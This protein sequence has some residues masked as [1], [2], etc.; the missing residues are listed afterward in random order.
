MPYEA[1]KAIAATFC[2]KIR[3]ILTPLFGTDFPS[4]CISPSDRARFGRMIIDPAI[5]QRA[6]GIANKYQ[7]L[8]LQTRTLTLA[9]SENESATSSTSERRAMEDAALD[10]CPPRQLFPK[11][12]RH[13][14]TDSVGSAR[15]SSSEPYCVSPH[16]PTGS[17]W[18]PVNRPPPRSSEIVSMSRVPSPAHYLS[19]VAELQKKH[20][21]A[22]ESEWDTDLSSE[23][24]SDAIRTPELSPSNEDSEMPDLDAASADV[25]T[26]A[27]VSDMSLPG[28]DGSVTNDEQDEQCRERRARTSVQNESP[29][30]QEQLHK[31][32]A[33]SATTCAP[34][35]SGHFAHEVKAAHALLRLHMQEAT[36]ADDIE[37]DHWMDEGPRRSVLGLALRPSSS[38]SSRKRRRASL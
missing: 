20:R 28:D 34:G 33:R 8:E 2:W 26:N 10:D 36:N 35:G 4:L 13:R 17:T 7:A 37:D 5:V 29:R 21:S 38:S 32:S 18:T 15:D 3:Y 23:A 31:T 22:E 24:P 25:D 12:P 11:V 6:A 9:G 19:Y 27:S 1:A 30:K 14:Y 16:S